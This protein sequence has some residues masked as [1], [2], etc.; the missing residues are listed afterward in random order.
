MALVRG[1]AFVIV[2]LGKYERAPP[3]NLTAVPQTTRSYSSAEA[4]ANQQRVRSS[5]QEP[6]PAG[7]HE[8][9]PAG[10]DPPRRRDDVLGAAFD[11]VLL[12]PPPP[13]GRR[14]PLCRAALGKPP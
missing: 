6:P 12:P 2:L 3:Y 14:S 10:R 8:P 7:R 13:P 11:E 5:L 4:V 1:I 9:P